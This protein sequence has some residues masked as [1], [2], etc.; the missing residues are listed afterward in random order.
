MTTATCIICSLKSV[1]VFFS[2]IFLNSDF[3]IYL[4]TDSFIIWL[5]THVAGKREWAN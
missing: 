4:L 1:L 5:I 3:L 2:L